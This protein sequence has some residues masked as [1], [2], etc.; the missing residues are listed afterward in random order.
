[1]SWMLRWQKFCQRSRRARLRAKHR[2][3]SLRASLTLQPAQLHPLTQ[4][5][6]PLRIVAGRHDDPTNPPSFLLTLAAPPSL[7]L[8]ACLLQTPLTYPSRAGTLA[9]LLAPGRLPR[10]PPIMCGHLRRLRRMSRPIST[11]AL[12]RERRL[13]DMAVALGGRCLLLRCSLTL[14]APRHL[15][16]TLQFQSLLGQTLTMSLGPNRHQ[17]LVTLSRSETPTCHNRKRL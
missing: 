8:P 12:G 9:L 11:A 16:M 14:L 5:Y 6:H 17:T 2:S 10:F 15:Q 13:P 7:T 4:A 3:R 1:M